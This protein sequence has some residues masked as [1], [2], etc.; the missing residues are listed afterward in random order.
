MPGVGLSVLLLL[1]P[2]LL[3]VLIAVPGED[4]LAEGVVLYCICLLSLCRDPL[5]GE[6]CLKCI[7]RTILVLELRKK[8]QVLAPVLVSVMWS[9]CG[10]FQT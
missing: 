6:E 7:A 9:V 4:M 2:L 5:A 10:P 1:V 3:V 8:G